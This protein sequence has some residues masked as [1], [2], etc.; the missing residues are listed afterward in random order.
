MNWRTE[1]EKEKGDQL[2]GDGIAGSTM[3]FLKVSLIG[4]AQLFAAADCDCVATPFLFGLRTWN[5]D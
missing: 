4:T 1:G 5:Y 3:K 2:E